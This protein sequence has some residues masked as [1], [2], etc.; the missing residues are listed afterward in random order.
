MYNLQSKLIFYNALTKGFIVLI[1]GCFVMIFLDEISYSQLDVRLQDKANRLIKNI[2]DEEVYNRLF[3][4]KSLS[5]YNVLKEEYISLNK[6]KSIVDSVNPNFITTPKTVG[7]ETESFRIISYYFK[8]KGELY[9]LEIGQSLVVI[10]RLK[11][12]ILL[13]TIFAVLISLGISLVID[14]LFNRVL[15]RPFYKIVDQKINKVNDP[16][17]YNHQLIKTTTQDFR[18]L[19]ESISGLMNKVSNFILKEKQF[20]ANVSHELL[21]P[22]SIL[23]IRFENILND[24][25]LNKQQARKI[26]DSI[27]TL[28]RLKGVVNS[29]LLISKIENHQFNKPDII[30]IENMITDVI[31]ELQDRADDK[32]ISIS[33]EIQY[34]FNS[35]VNEDL[36]HT[37]FFN[38]I[39]N[40]IKYNNADG[41]IIVKDKTSNEYYNI[42][43]V[44]TGKGMEKEAI[45]QAFNRFE[46]AEENEVV[47]SHG[48]GLAIVK[49][50]AQFHQIDVEIKSD[51]GVGTTFILRFP[52]QFMF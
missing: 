18:A 31:Y 52:N 29:L 20:I 36:I 21:T 33:N 41:R 28:Q 7:N 16:L 38:I 30:S 4:N 46:K 5:D 2:S 26:F 8:H 1:L 10:M 9:H 24:E 13:I 3:D 45:E 14:I 12:T 23:S 43:I 50:I 39:N 35:Y 34:H 32:N 17:S 27:K 6:A 44:D 37:L 42:Y 19:D 48:L 11:R 22:I 15:L 40:A 49:S 51:L 25:N 47:E